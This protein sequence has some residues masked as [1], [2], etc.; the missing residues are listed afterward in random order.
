MLD[1]K[2]QIESLAISSGVP[3]SSLRTGCYMDAWLTFFPILMQLGLYTFPIASGHRFSFT[4]Q[5]DVARVAAILV[6]HQTVLRGSI[7]VIDPLPYTL[8]DVVRLY[9]TAAKRRLWPLGRWLLPVLKL[10]KPS[11]F[12][13]IYPTGA[14]RVTLFSY[15]N[16]NDW[17]G[18]PRSLSDLLPEFRITTMLDYCRSQAC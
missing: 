7:D 14:S 3:F 9:K 13:W 6:H 15:F 17:V 1:V 8:E 16:Q 5:G 11:V 10:L 18:D 4:C 12:R 2:G